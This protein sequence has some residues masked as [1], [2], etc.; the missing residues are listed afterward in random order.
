MVKNIFIK[1]IQNIYSNT[2]TISENNPNYLI[3]YLLIIIMLVLF[4]FLR[5]KADFKIV[6]K[7]WDIYRCH[8]KYAF[9][10]GLVHKEPGIDSITYTAQNIGHCISG[11]LSGP[12]NDALDKMDK[13]KNIEDVKFANF[14]GG[15]VNMM[16]KFSNIVSYTNRI[17]TTLYNTMQNIFTNNQENSL[18]LLMFFRNIGIYFDQVKVSLSYVVSYLYSMFNMMEKYHKGKEEYNLKRK[19]IFSKW[20]HGNAIERHRKGKRSAASMK[21]NIYS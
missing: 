4:I 16:K 10:A 6:D 9:I 1:T 11:T 7:E 21:K 2:E 13:I 19:G 14:E 5:M 18:V 8:P 17:T 15:I 20:Y 12:L 3:A